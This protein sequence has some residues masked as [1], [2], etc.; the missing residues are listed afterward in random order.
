[1]IV[2]RVWATPITVFLFHIGQS[3]DLEMDEIVVVQIPLQMQELALQFYSP[4]EKQS[5]VEDG[6]KQIGTHI[7]RII[8]QWV[9]MLAYV[10]STSLGKKP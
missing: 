7:E 8:F 10:S 2:P 6:L 4:I 3:S 1:M 9:G 5:S